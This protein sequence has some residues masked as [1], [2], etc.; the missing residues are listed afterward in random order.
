MTGVMPRIASTSSA[1]PLPS[2]PAIP[3]ISPPR[4]SKDTFRSRRAPASS[5]AEM[6]STSTA[7]RSVTAAFRVSGVGSSEPTIS[8][9]RSAAVTSCGF[10]AATERPWRNTVMASATARTSSSLW[11]MKMMV[12]PSAASSRM[13]RNSSSTSCGTSTA[14]GSSKIRMRA[15]R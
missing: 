13:L 2:T 7:A 9:A 14:V 1:W 5:T 6:F 4:T 15:P 11:S 8:S 3:A 12:W 10:T